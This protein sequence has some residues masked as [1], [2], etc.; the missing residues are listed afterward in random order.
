MF[1]FLTPLALLG[2]GLPVHAQ[3]VAA[4]DRPLELAQ[5]IA[6]A[7]Q[8]NP[9]LAAAGHELQASAGAALQADMLPNPTVSFEVQDSRR[10]TR[11]TTL[12]VSQPIEL[13]GKRAYRTAV[14]ARTQ[15]MAA[16]QLQAKRLEVRADVRKAFYGVL[17]AEE[18]MNLAQA[19]LRN[20][21]RATTV[22]ARRVL[23]GKISPVD[24]DK[25]RV[26]EAV[27]RL[28]LLQATS[29]LATARAQ[30]AALWGSRTVNFSR[31]AGTLEGVPVFP[32]LDVLVQRLVSAPA[33]LAARTDTERHAALANL[34]KSR[35]TGDVAVSLGVKRSEELGRNQAIVGFSI[36]LPLFARNQGAVLD[37][38]RRLDKSRDDFDAAA[39][40]LHAEL[41]QA[42]ARFEL[43][44]QQA[45]AMREDILPRAT[46][47][48]DAATTGFE[49]GKFALI[50]VLDAQRTLLQTRSHYLQA[51]G[52][53]HR[54]AAD[55]DKLAGPALAASPLTERVTP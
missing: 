26:A 11:E 28:E 5:A 23:A 22:A 15:D 17:I 27:V 36:P 32:P 55:I 10:A 42:H 8:A 14:A 12:Q 3:S 34:E 16:L 54:A 19:S 46:S 7:L 51:L 41:L 31:I 2:A 4:P 35:R 48:L 38:L 40:T 44:R 52:E 45:A 39:L 50:D 30:L 1:R 53:L 9:Q 6:L 13:G 24:E 25:A 37:S 29:E 49:F 33:L 47:A 43:A 20:A 21:G 18:R